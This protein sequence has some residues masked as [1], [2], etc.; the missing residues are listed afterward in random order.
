MSEVVVNVSSLVS[1]SQAYIVPQ[2]V[3]RPQRPLAASSNG[4]NPV[5]NAEVTSRRAARCRPRRLRRSGLTRRSLFPTADRTGSY[6][7]AFLGF[8][9]AALV[10]IVL[11]QMAR[12]PVRPRGTG[13]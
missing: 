5:D 2:A 8:S 12:P 4:R 9:G 7:G 10:A 11:V 13:W 1:R 6:S 3:W